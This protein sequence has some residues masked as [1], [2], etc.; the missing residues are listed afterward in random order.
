MWGSGAARLSSL[1][2]FGQFFGRIGEDFGQRRVVVGDFGQ[3]VYRAAKIH[4][5]DQL[6]YQF[7]GLGPDDMRAENL[8]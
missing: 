6:V 8:A 1:E 5:R 3:I 4:Y 2:L 7:T